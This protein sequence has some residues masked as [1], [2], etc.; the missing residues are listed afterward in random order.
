MAAEILEAMN[1]A[2]T[3]DVHDDWCYKCRKFYDCCKDVASKV[4]LVVKEGLYQTKI[5]L[6]CEKK[7][8]EIKITYTKKL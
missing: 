6:I 8:H 7:S 1:V 5:K 2:F 3:D 4:G